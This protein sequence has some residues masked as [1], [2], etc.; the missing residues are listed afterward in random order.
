MG[1][2][3]IVISGPPGAGSSTVSK[4]IAKKLKLEYF[5]FGELHKKMTANW[6][7]MEAKAALD[8]WKTEGGASEKTHVERDAMQTNIAKRGNIVICGKLSI[9]FLR[10]LTHYKIWI[11]APLNIRAVR[12]AKR[13]KI[14]IKEAKKHIWERENI[15]RE[16]WKK[17][18]GFDYFDQKKDADLV[19]DSSK[20]SVEETVRKIVGFIKER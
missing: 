16:S 5:S 7:K 11:D 20:L 4:Q 17:I 14:P 3:V 6:E 19:I 9:H 18:Y 10:D 1:K 12:S 8:S 2:L 15:E 13:D